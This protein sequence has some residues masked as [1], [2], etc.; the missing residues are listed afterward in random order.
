MTLTDPQ[1][2]NL[3]RNYGIEKCHIKHLPIG[4]K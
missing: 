2:V 4:V 3:I 1:D